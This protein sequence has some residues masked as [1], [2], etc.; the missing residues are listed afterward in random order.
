[1]TDPQVY[2]PPRYDEYDD[3]D[4]VQIDPVYLAKTRLYGLARYG[5]RGWQWFSYRPEQPDNERH[6]R[7]NRNGEGL[8][9]DRRS[10]PDGTSE[11]AQQNGTADWSPD[12]DEPGAKSSIA[13]RLHG[14][15]DAED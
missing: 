3:E 11:W 14:E 1:M 13:Q 8:F 2:I 10:G 4:A 6:W 9:S 12:A 5:E 7:T 15:W